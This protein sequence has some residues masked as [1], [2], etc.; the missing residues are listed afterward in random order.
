MTETAAATTKPYPPASKSWI[1]VIALTVAYVFSYAD[2]KIIELLIEPI[3]AD[4]DL[5]DEQIG[6]ILGPAFSLVYVTSGLFIGWL[7]DRVRRTWLVA[8]GV[9]FWSLATAVSGVAQNFWQMFMARLSVGAG[10]ATLSPA[11]FSMIGDSFPPEERGKPIAFYT[12][13]LV[14]GASVAGFLGGGIL[15]WAKTTQGIDV[16]LLGMLAPWQ[17]AFFMI[18]LPGLLVAV[19][20]FFLQEPER[21]P[22]TIEDDSLKGNNVGDALGYIAKYWGTYLG[23]V[24]IVCVMT[25][26]AYS[27]G[28]LASTFNRVWG[29]ET[30][31]YAIVNATALLIIGPANILAWGYLSDRWTKAGMRDA[32]FRIMAGGLLIMVPTGVIAMFMPTGWTAYA[33]LCVN[34]IGIGMVSGV[35]VTALL[36]ITPAQIRGQVVALYYMAISMAGLWLGFPTVGTLSSR[37]FGEDNLN[38]AV[39]VVPIIYGTIPILLL[40]VICRLYVAQMNRLSGETEAQEAAS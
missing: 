29:W 22:T 23:F 39:G 26:V 19:W 21:R 10:E 20:I 12:M 35:G 11:T 37:V 7:V 9:A 1:L 5:S 6:L 8:A 13:A 38:L 40:P 32:P 24:S 18:G 16:P 31:Y 33:V 25:I 2:R 4:L 27:Q 14:V 36:L 34:T 15:I 30:E 17:L 28:F 3:K